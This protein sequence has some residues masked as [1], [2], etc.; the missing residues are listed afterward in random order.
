MTAIEQIAKELFYKQQAR[1]L[2][3]SHNKPFSVYRDGE[4]LYCRCSIP[5]MDTEAKDNGW[6][7][8]FTTYPQ[9]YVK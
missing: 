5:S 8:V 9:G 2:A 6:E 7:W 3:Q 4:C 1:Q